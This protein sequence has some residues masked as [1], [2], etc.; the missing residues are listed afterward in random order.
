MAKVNL[1]G[2]QNI[3]FENNQGD[4][5]KGIK[6]H[7]TYKDENVAGEKCDS[8][9]ISAA[10]CKNLGI[11]FDDMLS[12]VG[13]EVDIEQNLNGKVVGINPV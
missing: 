2:V 6:L 3:D 11:E 13:S 8:K 9:F 1:L 4:T 10:A 5:V 12:L 7:V